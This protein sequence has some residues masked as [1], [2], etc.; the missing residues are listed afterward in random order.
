[1]LSSDLFIQNLLEH[2]QRSFDKSCFTNKIPRCF[3]LLSAELPLF[4][5]KLTSFHLVFLLIFV[6]AY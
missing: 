6:S 1:M 3:K 5:L 2:L 4:F